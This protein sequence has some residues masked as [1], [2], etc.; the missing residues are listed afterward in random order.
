M[1]HAWC[2]CT[3]QLTFAI[4]GGVAKWPLADVAACD[5]TCPSDIVLARSTLCWHHG[6]VVLIVFM[7]LSPGSILPCIVG[8]KLVKAP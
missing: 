6:V 3:A 1:V 4:G 8:N 2:T 5:S 7:F